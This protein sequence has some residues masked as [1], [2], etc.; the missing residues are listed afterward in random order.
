MGR[1]GGIVIGPQRLS[2][3]FS[4]AEEIQDILGSCGT[5]QVSF[6]DSKCGG[7]ECDG[8]HVAEAGC[9]GP[10]GDW[11]FSPD[12]RSLHVSPLGIHEAARQLPRC[13][14]VIVICVPL[15]LFRTTLG[16]PG[17]KCGGIPLWGHCMDTWVGPGR[18]FCPQGL[19]QSQLP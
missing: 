9:T 16:K 5:S 7:V 15:L 12:G 17:S 19:H 8:A 3:R 11:L 1:R 14:F 13:A 18:G 2:R 10:E 6:L 4:G